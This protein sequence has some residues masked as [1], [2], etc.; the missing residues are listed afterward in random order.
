MEACPACGFSVNAGTKSRASAVSDLS[1]SEP[2]AVDKTA[3]RRDERAHATGCEEGRP[4]AGRARAG[5]DLGGFRR[6]RHHRRHGPRRLDAADVQPRGLES[7]PPA[8]HAGQLHRAAGRAVGGHG[9]R[10]LRT[11]TAPGA[12]GSGGSPAWALAGA[13]P[14]GAARR[15]LLARDRA[16]SRGRLATC[17]LLAI[18]TRARSWTRC[19]SS[20]S[21]PKAQAMFGAAIVLWLVGAAARQS[22][23]PRLQRRGRRS[24]RWRPGSLFAVGAARRAC[25]TSPRQ[26]Y[27]LEESDT[28]LSL[29]QIAAEVLERV[30]LRPIADRDPARDGRIRDPVRA[31]CTRATTTGRE[32]ADPRPQQRADALGDVPGLADLL[33]RAGSRS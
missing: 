15:P 31:S 32:G 4:E 19:G 12:S 33:G 24:S 26:Y 7:R 23:L 30:K 1:W 29:D 8:Q 13:R 28:R 18:A 3:F 25:S 20:R 22:R 2:G 14:R 27:P 16:A 6:R 21:Q 17:P 10:A 5:R 11:S 9:V